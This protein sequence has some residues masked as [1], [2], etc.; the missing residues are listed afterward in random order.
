MGTLPLRHALKLCAMKVGTFRAAGEPSEM[1]KETGG[2][3]Q[4]LGG[5]HCDKGQT[6]KELRPPL[7]AAA[8]GSNSF[9]LPICVH[10]RP[11]AGKTLSSF[12]L[13]PS[14]YMLISPS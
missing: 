6:G 4:K 3:A 5:G 14:A 8:R 7:G 13:T 11:S 1:R 2:A 9:S 12:P 10:R